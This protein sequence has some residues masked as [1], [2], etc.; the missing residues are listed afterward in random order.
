MEPEGSKNQV[1]ENQ[2]FFKIM[3]VGQNSVGTETRVS[4][5]NGAFAYR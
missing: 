1:T 4:A 3:N 5:K 2:R